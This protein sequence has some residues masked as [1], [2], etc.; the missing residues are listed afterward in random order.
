VADQHGET[1]S[2][3]QLDDTQPGTSKRTRRLA[4]AVA[5]GAVLAI[6]GGIA[7]AASVGRPTNRPADPP[8]SV[9]AGGGNHA[10]PGWRLESSLGAEIAVPAN[11]AVNDSGCGMTDRP[12]VVRAK[13]I[14]TACYTPEPAT[15]ELAIIAATTAYGETAKPVTIDGVAA[16][17]GERRLDDGRYAAWIEV[18]SRQVAIDVRTRDAATAKRIVDSLRLVDTDNLGC[19]TDPAKLTPSHRHQPFVPADP[20]SIRVC[21]YGGQERLQ[22][23]AELT[24]DNAR[25][26]ATALNAA[27]PGRNPDRSADSCTD[28]A[29]PP[30][31]DA[32]L[33]ARAGGDVTT[34]RVRFGACTGRGADNGSATVQVTQGIVKL[35]M[36]PIHA[37]YSLGDLPA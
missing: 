34:V 30:G 1:G 33:L 12:S 28:S 15:K 17:R 9:D 2:Q 23:S 36:E 31:D 3:G 16:R 11:W 35:F 24:S 4:V 37:G 8:P 6:T 25:R 20:T 27:P 13:G 5:A 19:T 14:S 29:N 21:Y 10:N 7:F 26:L 18:P 22:A 32:V